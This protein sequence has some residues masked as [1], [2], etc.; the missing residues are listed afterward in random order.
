MRTNKYS[1]DTSL[2]AGRPFGRDGRGL[3]QG[4]RPYK[5]GD[6]KISIWEDRVHF[7]S[8]DDEG[9]VSYIIAED[10]RGRLVVETYRNRLRR[11]LYK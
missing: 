7:H 2:V 6:E 3:Y 5:L 8:K 9:P 11:I 1:V 4:V 10:W